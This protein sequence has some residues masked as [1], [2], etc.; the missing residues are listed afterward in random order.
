MLIPPRDRTPEFYMGSREYDPKHLGYAIQT[1]GK[2]FLLDTSVKGNWNIGHGFTA[3]KETYA[4]HRADYKNNPLPK[5]VIGPLLTDEERFAIIEY[6]K[7][8]HRQN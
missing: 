8:K 7:I 4:K 6:L 5:G 2:G 1:D 3:D